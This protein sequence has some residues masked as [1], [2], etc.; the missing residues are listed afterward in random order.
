VQ[1]VDKL[2]M[3]RRIKRIREAVR[4]KKLPHPPGDASL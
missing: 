2:L 3:L 4:E 1:R